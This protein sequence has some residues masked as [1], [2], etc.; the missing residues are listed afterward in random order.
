ML[1]GHKGAQK[2]CRLTEGI[3]RYQDTHVYYA[4]KTS[5]RRAPY[6]A[7]KTLGNNADSQKA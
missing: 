3:G 6:L 7:I 5:T 2:Q 1:F 4:V